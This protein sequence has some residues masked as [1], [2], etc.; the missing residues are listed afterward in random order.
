MEPNPIA[1]GGMRF[2]FPPYG[3]FPH[4]IYE[5]HKMSGN[6]SKLISKQK[7]RRMQGIVHRLESLCQ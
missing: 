2:T 3:V 7:I 5:F 6:L 4:F 1:E